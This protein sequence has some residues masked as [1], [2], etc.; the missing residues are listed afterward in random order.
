[1]FRA[2]ASP[3]SGGGHVMGCI[4]PGFGLAPKEFP[5][6]LGKR[7]ARDLKRGEPLDWDM[8]G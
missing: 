5:T 3:E 4:R 6:V 7:A 1:M 2:D 8:V